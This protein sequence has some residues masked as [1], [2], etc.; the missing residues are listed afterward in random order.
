MTFGFP[1]YDRDQ[2]VEAAKLQ[3]AKGVNRLKMVVGV[4]KGGWR[5]DARRIRAV[6]DAIGAD[7]DLMIDGNY[8]L[9]P[10]E[11]KML[12]RGIED[13]HIISYRPS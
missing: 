3:V 9:A 8:K 10:V 2:V 5:E 11:A 6:R 1:E 4:D 13:C 7:V 12:C